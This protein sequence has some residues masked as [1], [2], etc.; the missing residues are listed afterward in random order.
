MK[1][2]DEKNENLF[3]KLISKFDYSENKNK[4]FEIIK[5]LL[6]KID[7]LDNQKDKNLISRIENFV[8]QLELA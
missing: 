6:L 8:R 5:Q 2:I 3:N 4:K 1:T 7:K